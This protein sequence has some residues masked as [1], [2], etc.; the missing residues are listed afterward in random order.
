MPYPRAEQRGLRDRGRR[1]GTHCCCSNW[2]RTLLAVLAGSATSL[3]AAAGA[4]AAE[5][6]TARFTFTGAEQAFVVPA[7]V[8]TLA[9]RA[10]GGTGKGGGAPAEAKGNI[11]V[12]PGQS[13][14]VEVGGSPTGRAGGFNGGG[15][16]GNS[17]AGGGGGASDVRTV[18]RASSGTLTSR[19]IVAGASGGASST[20]NAGG[21]AGAEG[22][23]FEEG[24]KPGTQTEGGESEELW[25]CW[26]EKEHEGKHEGGTPGQLGIGGEGEGCRSK[27]HGD[28]GGGGGGAGL[29][30]GGGG[31]VEF[32]VEPPYEFASGGGGGS[33]LVPGRGLALAEA[34]PPRSN[35]PTAPR[36]GAGGGDR[37]GIR[38]G[39]PPRRL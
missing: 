38:C 4:H 27:S 35:S 11:S 12:T 13:L 36:P 2:F 26:I 28:V 29:Y 14:Y 5:T 33:S 21:A 32:D 37:S 23:P 15:Q 34:C 17:T 39:G 18:A 1:R 10:V 3:L 31:G 20:G 7:G 30:G 6:V 25:E 9:V 22:L 19:L 24:G 16:G 8:T